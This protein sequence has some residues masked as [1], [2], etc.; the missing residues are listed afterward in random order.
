MRLSEMSAGLQVALALV[1]WLL[2]AISPAARLAFEDR[3]VPREKRRGASIFPVWPFY[4]LVLLAPL[5]FLG[6]RHL[7]MTIIAVCHVALLVWALGF[8]GYWLVRARR[9]G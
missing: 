7:V 8:I 3:K 1:A 4:P 9:A 6:A 2:F 5:P